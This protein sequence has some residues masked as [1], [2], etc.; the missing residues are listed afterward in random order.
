MVVVVVVV[1]AG[2]YTV[3]PLEPGITHITRTTKDNHRRT[4]SDFAKRSG[5][6]GLRVKLQ[7][8]DRVCGAWRRPLPPSGGQCARA[9]RG[10]NGKRKRKRGNAK[11]LKGDREGGTSAKR[12]RRERMR[13]LA[14]LSAGKNLG[15]TPPC[16]LPSTDRRDSL[17]V[18]NA[19]ACPA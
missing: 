1:V 10:G 16:P 6:S 8:V 14:G 18:S 19:L 7:V 5:N 13:N 9:L 11:T 17:R 4:V 2:V 12:T 15:R 3:F